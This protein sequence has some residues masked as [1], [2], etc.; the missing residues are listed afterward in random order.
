MKNGCTGGGV[1]LYSRQDLT[2]NYGNQTPVRV[3]D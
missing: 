1:V 2:L 3:W